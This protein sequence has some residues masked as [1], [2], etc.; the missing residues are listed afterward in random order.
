MG[1]CDVTRLELRLTVISIILLTDVILTG[2]AIAASIE[3]RSKSLVTVENHIDKGEV[4]TVLSSEAP[5]V[6]HHSCRRLTP[7]CTVLQYK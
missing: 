7:G 3:I 5:L 2:L 6:W 4:V 1:F